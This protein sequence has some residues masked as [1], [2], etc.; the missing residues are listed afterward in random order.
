MAAEPLVVWH[1]DE[2]RPRISLASPWEESLE[3]I[4]S[5]RPLFTPRAYAACVMSVIASMA[6]PSRSRTAFR[7]LLREAHQH[8][9]PGP[10]DYVTYAQIWLI[11]PDL[12][13]RL[14]DLALRG[15]RADGP[16]SATDGPASAARGPARS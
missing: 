13:H 5:R 3:W 2:N 10:L 8:G 7:T 11:P 4:R 16:A 12:R 15:R 14:R 1:T 6:A 9:R